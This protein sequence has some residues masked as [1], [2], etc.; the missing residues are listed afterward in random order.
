MNYLTLLKEAGR[1]YDVFAEQIAN[2]LSDPERVK[3]YEKYLVQVGFK[4]SI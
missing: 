2:E 4:K 1:N 3:F